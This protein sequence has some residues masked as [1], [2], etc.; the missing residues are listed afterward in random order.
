MDGNQSVVQ[1]LRSTTLRAQR[2]KLAG[3]TRPTQLGSSSSPP[4]LPPCQCSQRHNGH[5][6]NH[7]QLCLPSCRTTPHHGAR[8]AQ[9]PPPAPRPRRSLT[10]PR[11][12]QPQH[13]LGCLRPQMPCRLAP[14]VILHISQLFPD[15]PI[16]LCFLIY[17]VVDG[18]SLKWLEVEDSKFSLLF[19]L[20]DHA[21]HLISNLQKTSESYLSIFMNFC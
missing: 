12:R 6:L 8:L 15:F 17:F 19:T 7:T 2:C 10:G 3:I 21:E 20:N 9:A 1:G 14:Q 16:F 18:G 4:P 13:R 5:P 11:C